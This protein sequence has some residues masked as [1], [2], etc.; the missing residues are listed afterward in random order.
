ME[1]ALRLSKRELGIVVY[2][3]SKS[4]EQALTGKEHF[5]VLET[6]QGQE[7]SREYLDPF[8]VGYISACNKLLCLPPPQRTMGDVCCV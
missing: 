3:Q 2:G 4:S 1:L 5:V 8:P 7:I 6:I